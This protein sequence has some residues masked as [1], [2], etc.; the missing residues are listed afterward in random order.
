MRN[1]SFHGYGK[2]FLTVRNGELVVENV[3]V[4]RTGFYAPW[5]ARNI[6]F[7]NRLRTVELL[8]SLL[9]AAEDSDL[10]S[11]AETREVLLKVIEELNE[12]NL[13]KGSVLAVVLLPTEAD[14]ASN[15]SQSL[16]RFLRTELAEREIL[17]FD[18]VRDIRKLPPQ[19]LG[20][21]FIDQR[22]AAHRL[23]GGH[24]SVKGNEYIAGLLY[25]DLLTIPS[26]S[27]R[28]AERKID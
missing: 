26:L 1:R 4:P 9:P 22:S 13:A 21:L 12:L 8:R 25:E 19:E 6:Q 15:Q 28:L 18:L 11:A 5:F 24:Y 7:L 10:P 3:P 23:A 20:G 2:P 14:H 16:R 27:A 17:F